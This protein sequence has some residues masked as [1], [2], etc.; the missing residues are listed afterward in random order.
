M[1]VD[2]YD[3]GGVRRHQ[4]G[5]QRQSGTGRDVGYLLDEVCLRRVQ[6]ER[7]AVRLAVVQTSGPVDLDHVSFRIV[8]VK[9]ERTPVVQAHLDWGPALGDLAIECAQISQ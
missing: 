8:E 4:R 1:S 7:V 6:V 2:R 3:S 5:W 9:G